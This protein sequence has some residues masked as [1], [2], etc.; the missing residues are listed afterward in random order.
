MEIR[1]LFCSGGSKGGA[2]DAPPRAQILSISCSVWE[3]MVKLY[4]GAPRGVGAP[5]SGK[6]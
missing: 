1:A 2:R 6:S 5:S 3:N 4:V